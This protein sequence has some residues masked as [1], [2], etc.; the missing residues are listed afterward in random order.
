MID[1]T[2]A[3]T[4]FTVST[5]SNSQIR[6]DKD[7]MKKKLLAQGI[8]QETIDKGMDAVFEYAKAN[9]IQIA[10]PDGGKPPEGGQ[11]PQGDDTSIFAQQGDRPQG[12]PPP[13]KDNTDKTDEALLNIGIPVEVIAKGDTAIK[14]YAQE[15]D[16]TLPETY[17]ENSNTSLDLSA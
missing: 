6:P 2:S 8:P 16:I 17:S 15:N 11:M 7:E 14:Q 12:P 13:P 5:S 9:S 10:P 3:S 4:N 1:Q